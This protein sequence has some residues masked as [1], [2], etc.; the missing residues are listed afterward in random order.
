MK[1][2]ILDTETS[3]LDPARGA[4]VLELA[5]IEL[6]Q[7]DRLWKPTFSTDFYIQYQGPISPHAHATH[8]IDPLM[9]TAERGAHP[10]DEAI[11]FL[12]EHIEPDTIMV[13]HFASF[14]KAFFPQ[15]TRPW[16][17]TY[18][19]AKHVWPAAPGYSN[20]VLRYW[21]NLNLNKIEPKIEYRRPHQALYDAATTTGILL[22]MLEVHTPERLLHLSQAP[23]RLQKINFGKHKGMDF[24]LIPRDYL[25]WLRQRPDLEDDIKHTIDSILQP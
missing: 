22:K 12:L 17:C 16:I 20:Q 15:I 8:H 14:D 11:K 19:S 10:F 25:Q 7:E 23:L 24:D 2:M 18:R 3:D 5:W 1:L 21:L 4:K 6:V 9:L 13:A